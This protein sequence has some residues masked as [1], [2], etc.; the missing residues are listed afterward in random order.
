MPDRPSADAA[1]S[2]RSTLPIRPWTSTDSESVD[3]EIPW[4]DAVADRSPATSTRSGGRLEPATAVIRIPILGGATCRNRARRVIRTRS[5]SRRGLSRPVTIGDSVHIHPRR[6]F[7]LEPVAA[8]DSNPTPRPKSGPSRPESQ[9]P[10][11]PGAGAPSRIAARFDVSA[12]GA[13]GTH[14][15][16]PAPSGAGCPE[17]K[18]QHPPP[19][20]SGSSRNHPFRAEGIPR[21]QATISGPPLPEIP[22]R[23]IN[24]SAAATTGASASAGSMARRPGSSS[25]R[26]W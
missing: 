10:R 15:R 3:G 19:R 4:S 6:G 2:S 7:P 8:G 1:A 23:S 26:S 22:R 25:K 24:S 18:H 14:A 17:L 20:R 12:P 5:L 9:K 11:N 21:G 16:R 13:G